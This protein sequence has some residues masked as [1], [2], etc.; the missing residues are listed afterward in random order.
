M[1]SLISKATKTSHTGHAGDGSHVNT[2]PVGDTRRMFLRDLIIDCEIGVYP[3]ERDRKQRV[4]FNIDAVVSD[5]PV[6]GDD[7]A[8]VVSYELLR[9]AAHRVTTGGHTNLVETMAERLAALCLVHPAILEVTI[10]VEKLDVFE[11]CAGAGIE[12]TR[13]RA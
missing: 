2:Q 3:E 12:I 11:D 5:R 9:D 7:I 1:I 8:D 13:R 4:C 6:S 10:R